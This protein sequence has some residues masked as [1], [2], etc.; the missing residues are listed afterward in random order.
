MPTA[1]AA[2]LPATVKPSK[3]TITLQPDL[4]AFTFT[5]QETVDIQ[6]LE[7]TSQIVVNAVDLEIQSC[8]LTRDDEAALEPVISL[9]KDAG[10]R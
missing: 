5:G 3:Y 9:D 6:V 8:S 2:I 7:S 1:E 10:G 4:E